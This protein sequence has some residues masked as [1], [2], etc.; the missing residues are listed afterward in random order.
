MAVE[1]QEDGIKGLEAIAMSAGQ[2]GGL[3]IGPKA[4]KIEQN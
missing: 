2:T 3:P 4:A 1:A